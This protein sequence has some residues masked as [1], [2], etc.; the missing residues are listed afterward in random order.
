MQKHTGLRLR[1]PAAALLLALALSLFPG[2]ARQTAAQGLATGCAAAAFFDPDSL[3]EAFG[4]SFRTEPAGSLE[5][6]FRVA[7]SAV[8]LDGIR[9]LVFCLDGSEAA[10]GYSALLP[11]AADNVEKIG[12]LDLYAARYGGYFAEESEVFRLDGRSSA[13]SCVR[14]LKTLCDAKGVGFTLLFLPLHESRLRSLDQSDL[15]RYKKSL[16]SVCDL[17]DFSRSALS[18]DMRYFYTKDC[19]RTSTL[20]MA[21]RRIAGED[22]PAES[23][24]MR[25]T[26]SRAETQLAAVQSAPLPE[27]DSGYTCR[28][29]ILLYHNITENPVS[30]ADISPAAFRS[31]MEALCAAGYTAVTAADLIAYVEQGVPLPEKPVWI[32][33][34]DGYLSNYTIAFPILRELGMRATVFAIGVSMGK[35]TYKDTGYAITPHF[36][37]AQAREMTASG[38]MEI[39]SHTWDLHQ[40]APFE[41][42]PAAARTTALPLPGESS[43][44]FLAALRADYAAYQAAWGSGFYAL[45]Y[46]KGQY[47]AD[48]EA[49]FRSLG[50]RLT[51]STTTDR[52]NILIQGLPQ[53]LSALCR[54]DIPEGMTPEALLALLETE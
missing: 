43:E 6:A 21:L 26:A 20:D 10:G 41:P 29:P 45:A 1:M 37:Q 4:L 7:W 51:V 54:F 8:S 33:F 48:S 32:T 38:V 23:F 5:E 28:V 31:H 39:Q 52:Q 49:L 15:L 3:E 12:Q 19:A 42:D 34:D 53:S 44:R 14:Q 16:A 27:N 46:P 25:V 24:G 50:V 35:S 2:A 17:W 13:V 22:I 11:T 47:T 36:S 9:H 30:R 40:Y 18:A